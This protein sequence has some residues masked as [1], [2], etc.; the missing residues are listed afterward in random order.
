VAAPHGSLGVLSEAAAFSFCSGRPPC[1]TSALLASR[2]QMSGPTTD[3][4][5]PWS[6]DSLMNSSDEEDETDMP[7][8]KMTV[9]I[10]EYAL[11]AADQAASGELDAGSAAEID[12][13]FKANSV[14]GGKE[15]DNCIALAKQVGCTPGRLFT[16]FKKRR[17]A[18][19]T[20][21]AAAGELDAETAAEIDKLFKANSVLGDVK[22][23]N[24]QNHRSR[25][26]A[27]PGG[28][29]SPVSRPRRLR[30][31]GPCDSWRPGWL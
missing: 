22:S 24:S 26:H 6:F 23:D 25:C 17:A 12:K 18:A 2:R 1:S 21:R 3:D 14:L 5:G 16:E 20:Q 13:L 10:V 19:G 27:T 29:P 30:R 7:D 9:I 11:F 28:P 4:G 15:S 31:S 8:N